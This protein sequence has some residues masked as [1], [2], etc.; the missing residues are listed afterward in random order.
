MAIINVSEITEFTVSKCLSCCIHVTHLSTGEVLLTQ[1]LS[2]CINLLHDVAQQAD[3]IC[4][5]MGL[6]W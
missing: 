4:E 3:S 5:M 1:I 6:I 2:H